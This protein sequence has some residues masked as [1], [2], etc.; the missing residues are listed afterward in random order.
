[1]VIKNITSLNSIILD[2]FISIKPRL[3]SKGVRIY[4]TE[5]KFPTV[6]PRSLVSKDSTFLNQSQYQLYQLSKINCLL[7]YEISRKSSRVKILKEL[8]DTALQGIWNNDKL[9]NFFKTGPLSESSNELLASRNL[10]Q[11][12]IM[13]LVHLFANLNT[14][15]NILG[16]NYFF[17]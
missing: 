8:F 9:T 3:S 10:D 17:F 11:A 2:K 16:L 15:L 1:M 14:A 4:S 12:Y 6:E 13:E 5:Y 7:K